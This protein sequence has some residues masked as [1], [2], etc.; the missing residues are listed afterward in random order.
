MMRGNFSDF[1]ARRKG[2]SLLAASREKPVCQL[3]VITTSTLRANF[4]I[5][6]IDAS[7]TMPEERFASG[8]AVRAK[9]CDGWH[10]LGDRRVAF[11]GP[12]SV[13]WVI[14]VFE[15]HCHECTIL[16]AAEAERYHFVALNQETA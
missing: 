13:G 6:P 7:F 3:I 8:F 10:F 12:N 1:S 11:V 16:G 14:E 9:T 5:I 15:Q 4:V 2:F